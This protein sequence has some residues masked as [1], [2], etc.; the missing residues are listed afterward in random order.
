MDTGVTLVPRGV[1]RTSPQNSSM[2]PPGPVTGCDS[3]AEI[4]EL[5][6]LW[7]KGTC[8]SL[9]GFLG[10]ETSPGAIPGGHVWRYIYIYYTYTYIYIYIYIRIKFHPSSQRGIQGLLPTAHSQAGTG[11]SV[12]SGHDT[13]Q[14]PS[15]WLMSYHRF[16]SFSSHNPLW[17]WM[18]DP[19]VPGHWARRVP[20]AWS[21]LCSSENTVW[22][23]A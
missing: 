23:M 16:C 7:I 20:P 21:I 18:Q 9:R 12:P 6:G 15:L 17:K 5:L 4:R 22:A 19:G 13:K 8:R 2:G 10:I 11:I 1:P 3:H 14:N